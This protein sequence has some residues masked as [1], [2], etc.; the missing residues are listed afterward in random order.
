MPLDSLR[1]DLRYALRGLRTHPAFALTVIVTIALG[2]GANATMFGIV[3]RLL[4][5]GPDQIDKPESV[6]LIETYSRAGGGFGNSS[7]SYAADTDYRDRAAGFS[8]VGVTTRS[9]PISLGSGRDA[10]QIAGSLC[11]A[12]FFTAVGVR[13]ALGRFFTTDEDD[14]H[15]PQDVAVLGYG[16][17]QRRFGG[18]PDAVGQVLD[19]GTQHFRVVGVAPKGFTGVDFSNVDVWL[20]ITAASELRFDTSPNWT[21][22]RTSTYLTIVARIKPGVSERLATEQATA[23]YR[24]GLREQLA[25]TPK[26]AKYIKPDSEFVDLASLVPGKAGRD[27]SST[28]K[29]QDLQVSRLLAIVSFVVLIIAC[30]NVANLLLVRGFGRRREIAVRLALG[31]GRARLI[32]QLLVE[33]LLLSTLGAIGALL[34][35]HWT[36]HGVR[37]LLLGQ[38]AWTTEA[39]DGRLLVFTGAMTIATGLLSSIV[40]AMSA[41]RTDVTTALKAGV[42]EGGGAHSPVRTALLVIQAALALVL[43]A[44]AGL[45]LRSVG[46]VDGLPLGLDLNRVLVADVSHKSAGLSSEDAHR[47]YMQFQSDVLRIP[48]IKSSAVSVGLPMLLSWG[49]DIFVPGR[50]LAPPEHSPSQYLVTSDYFSTMGI[51][52]VAGR[53]FTSTD[54][55]GGAPVAIISAKAASYYFAQ[56]NPVGQCIKVGSDT[57]PCTTIVGVAAN[58]IRQGIEDIVPQVYRPLDQL[59]DSYTA[60]T[61][62]HFGYELV[63]RTAGDA[64]RF[65]EPVR[66]LLQSAGASVPY[67]DVRPMR[68]LFG[69]R[70]RTW[71]LGAKVFSAFG[72]LALVLAAV[73]LYS[74]LAFSLAQ[75]AHEFG[76]RI[77]LGAQASNLLGLSLSKGLAPVVAGIGVG[78]VLAL[79]SGRLIASLLF[80][81]SPYDPVVL[82]GVCAILLT[83]AVAASLLPALRAT[84]I[85]PN[86]VLRSD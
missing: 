33:G 60:S 51:P 24:T 3:D 54:R 75:R 61:V 14:E 52:I 29:A 26:A 49:T 30:A 12:S 50:T 62:S 38:D 17:W 84:R 55:E 34:I 32:A 82:F 36:S 76:V 19:I 37:T 6:V 9:N 81:V 10:T 86:S 27:A 1:Q 66:R 4:F 57:M 15:N 18:R 41:S 35:A 13:P 39:I 59:P 40:P 48:G 83:T 64:G 20:P 31:V 45:F 77:A 72:A 16:Y 73:G 28:V 78:L 47:L 44:G 68:D 22:N 67:A 43:L 46:K 25:E 8:S 65:A 85:D 21:T 79:L 7:F 11:S 58:T 23:A 42:R 2:M 5:L 63:V 80:K 69:R 71:E 53:A 74:V 56:Q 70:I